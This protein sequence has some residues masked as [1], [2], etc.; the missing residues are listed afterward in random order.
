MLMGAHDDD[1]SSSK[2]V[3][4]LGHLLELQQLHDSWAVCWG[5]AQQLRRISRP[6]PDPD[7]GSGLA[8][9]HV[10]TGCCWATGPGLAAAEA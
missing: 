6:H 10:V 7:P 4:W 9:G 2:P 1:A 8:P 3:S 5:A